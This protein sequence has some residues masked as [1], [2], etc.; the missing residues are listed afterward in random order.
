MTYVKS[1]VPDDDVRI[2]II[3]FYFQNC[4][5]MLNKIYSYHLSKHILV[6]EQTNK[7]KIQ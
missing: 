4:K 7:R 6:L 3:I 2:Y 5:N 1:H